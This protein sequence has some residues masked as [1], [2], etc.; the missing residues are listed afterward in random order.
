MGDI[1]LNAAS[2]TSNEFDSNLRQDYI[3]KDFAELNWQM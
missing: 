1:I 2:L 3:Y